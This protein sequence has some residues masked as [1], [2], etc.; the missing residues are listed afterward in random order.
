MCLL[1]NK[2]AFFARKEGVGVNV[3]SKLARQVE[4]SYQVHQ[5]S[6]CEIVH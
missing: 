1:G 4:L 5:V 2:S 3:Q 6:E